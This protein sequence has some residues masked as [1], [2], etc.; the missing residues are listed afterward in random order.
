MAGILAADHT[1]LKTRIKVLS[2]TL[3]AVAPFGG[4]RPAARAGGAGAA[5]EDGGNDGERAAPGHRASL[6]V[7]RVDQSVA[8]RATW[9]TRS[10]S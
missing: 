3:V 4:A 5:G 6:G 9:A 10:R 2:P 7:G 8:P 1:D